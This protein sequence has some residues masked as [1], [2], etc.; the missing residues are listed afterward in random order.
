MIAVAPITPVTAPP[1]VPV[2][3]AKV[4]S[5]TLPDVQLAA[6]V[7]DIFTFPILRQY[8][9]NEVGD[10]LVQI[11]AWTQAGANL[12]EVIGA[13]P[14]TLRLLTQQLLSLDL[15][16][17]LDTIST[18]LVG[19]IAAVGLP[20]IE[21]SIELSERELARQL[22][23]ASASP[24]AFIGLALSFVGA[25]ETVLQAS[26][27]GGQQVV[28]AILTFDLGNIA[29]AFLDATRDFF[30]SFAVGG[31]ILVD[32]IVFYQ[33]TIAA[34]LAAQ[35]P[36]AMVATDAEL[37]GPTSVPDLDDDAKLL[38]LSTEPEPDGQELTKSDTAEEQGSGEEGSEE[39]GGGQEAGEDPAGAE[40]AEDTA[41]EKEVAE[42]DARETEE[43]VPD[44]AGNVQ[45]GGT[46][47]ISGATQT[48]QG[49]EESAD[50]GDT[51]TGDTESADVA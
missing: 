28:D 36:T 31:Q 26:I 15:L 47:A 44:P 30:A 21:S 25:V 2:A 45:D 4:R 1:D 11:G 27:I 40:E 17:A 13:V 32:G 14:E 50:T 41:S 7:A 51:D 18:A 38:T 12:A 6:S 39:Q 49:N 3:V 22:A 43:E 19:S 48:G 5:V 10:F 8:V 20:F 34:A 16:G 24:E 37:T 33:Q 35:P 23:L 9:I 46:T 42:E 29:T